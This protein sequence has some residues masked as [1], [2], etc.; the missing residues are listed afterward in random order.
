M[1]QQYKTSRSQSPYSRRRPRVTSFTGSD[2]NG[3]ISSTTNIC[4]LRI[5]SSTSSPSTTK[6]EPRSMSS[7]LRSKS[8]ARSRSLPRTGPSGTHSS[9]LVNRFRFKT[10][11]VGAS[12]SRSC[13]SPSQSN[14]SRPSS[15]CTFSRPARSPTLRPSQTGSKFKSSSTLS[16]LEYCS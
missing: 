7:R 9:S 14:N 11:A 12:L 1:S 16:S 5:V 2:R 15:R 10:L 6:M 8:S 13:T 4:P 3:L